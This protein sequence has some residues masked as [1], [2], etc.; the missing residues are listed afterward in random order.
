MYLPDKANIEIG[1]FAFDGC[2]NLK[3]VYV[4]P[5]LVEQNPNAFKSD[6]LKNVKMI[7]H[8][9]QTKTTEQG[10]VSTISNDDFFAK[11]DAIAAKEEHPDSSD[12]YY[13]G[14]RF[15]RARKD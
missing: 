4:R 3:C 12:L 6:E 15:N 5:E 1:H 10:S 8:Q 14:S 7:F 9:E 11:F 13:Y 2:H